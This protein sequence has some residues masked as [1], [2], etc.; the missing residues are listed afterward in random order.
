MSK[1]NISV[2]WISCY[3]YLA[4]LMHRGIA[5]DFLPLFDDSYAVLLTAW[6]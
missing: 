2:Q 1:A 3:V 5:N 4:L 6:D